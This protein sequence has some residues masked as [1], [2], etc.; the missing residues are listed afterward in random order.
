M[1]SGE[2]NE[3]KGYNGSI[4]VFYSFST[5]LFEL[6]LLFFFLFEKG[7]CLLIGH[8]LATLMARLSLALRLILGTGCLSVFLN[9]NGG[10]CVLYNPIFIHSLYET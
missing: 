9:G 5:D 10:G 1:F 4:D 2:V 6:V 7:I 8:L 3:G